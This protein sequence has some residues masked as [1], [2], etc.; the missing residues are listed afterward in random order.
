MHILFSESKQR[1]V[2]HFLTP[3]EIHVAR[4]VLALNIL[5]AVGSAASHHSS[6]KKPEEKKQEEGCKCNVM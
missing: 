5:P 6:S 3:E 1:W 4:L 2:V